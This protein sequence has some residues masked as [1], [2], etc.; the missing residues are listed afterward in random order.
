MTT[1]TIPNT[2]ASDTYLRGDKLEA[3]FA[4]AK[5]FLDVSGAVGIGSDNLAASVSIQP[6]QVAENRAL[7]YVTLTA[8][9]AAMLTSG[10]MVL[11]PLLDEVLLR[12]LTLNAYSTDGLACSASARLSGDAEDLTLTFDSSTEPNDAI[13][14]FSSGNAVKAGGSLILTVLDLSANVAAASATLCFSHKHTSK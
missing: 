6:E 13:V 4:Y 11:V 12:S 1:F 7:S 2:L 14:E 10:E 9:K 3:N 5:A 8:V